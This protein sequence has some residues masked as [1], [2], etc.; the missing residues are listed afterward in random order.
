MS[1][2]PGVAF[3]EENIWWVGESSHCIDASRWAVTR[4]DKN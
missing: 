4:L 1:V 3:E 2:V